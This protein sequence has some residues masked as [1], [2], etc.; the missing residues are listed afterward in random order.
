VVR[1]GESSSGSLSGL[2]FLETYWCKADLKVPIRIYQRRLG[3]AENRIAPGCRLEWIGDGV[4]R[5]VMDE[6]VALLD[7]EG[8]R[9]SWTV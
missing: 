7:G 5:A 2:V 9:N 6:F 3:D 4:G 1:G 8:T